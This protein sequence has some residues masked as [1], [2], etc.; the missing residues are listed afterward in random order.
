MGG[1]YGGKTMV[2]DDE[3]IRAEYFFISIEERIKDRFGKDLTAHERYGVY[4]KKLE[5]LEKAIRKGQAVRIGALAVV[6]CEVPDDAKQSLERANEGYGF[7]G[8][9]LIVGDKTEFFG[10]GHIEGGLIDNSTIGIGCI[11]INSFINDTKVSNDTEVRDSTLIGCTVTSRSDLR[12]VNATASDF[13]HT[14]LVDSVVKNG[15][16]DY[17]TGSSGRNEIGGAFR[18]CAIGYGPNGQIILTK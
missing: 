17:V 10:Y 15:V 1:M 11:V 16:F 14:K 9:T 6:G 5:E 8:A 4:A 7:V 13:S 3:A 2:L 12:S 18:S